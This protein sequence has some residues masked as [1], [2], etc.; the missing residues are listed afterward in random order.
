MHPWKRPGLRSPAGRPAARRSL[1]ACFLAAVA[2][3]LAPAATAEAAAADPSSIFHIDRNK[4]RNQVHYGVR[5][6]AECRPVGAEPVYNYWLRLEEDPPVTQPVKFFQQ[7]AY[8]FSRQNIED[9]GRIE[10]RLRA[11][12]DR[13]FVIRLVK[14]GGECR[15]EAFLTIDGREA[16]IEKVFVFADE[17]LFLPTVRY[18]ELFGRTNDGHSVYEKI[19][20]DD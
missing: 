5:A 20:V 13:Q 16:Y 2:C 18:I 7:A 3:A 8:G 10:V 4:N 14:V 11:L 19:A 15:A 12:P 1:A 17:G 6:D 9:D